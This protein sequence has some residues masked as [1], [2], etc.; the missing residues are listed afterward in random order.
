LN[1]DVVAA[2]DQVAEQQEGK[3]NGTSSGMSLT[4][5][6]LSTLRWIRKFFFVFGSKCVSYKSHRQ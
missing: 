2:A 6:T 1:F 4:L 5:Q 3:K